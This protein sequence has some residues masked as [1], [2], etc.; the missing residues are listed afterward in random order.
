[1]N[2]QKVHAINPEKVHKNGRIQNTVH[3]P[4]GL[5]EIGDRQLSH[6]PSARSSRVSP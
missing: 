6:A 4:A 2:G 5:T 1:M 3:I